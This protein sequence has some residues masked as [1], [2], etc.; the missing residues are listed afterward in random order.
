MNDNDPKVESLETRMA[1]L[2]RGLA[3]LDAVVRTLGDEL[4]ATR[5]E[6]ERVRLTQQAAGDELNSAAKW[7]VPPH[8]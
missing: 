5:A 8:Y 2:E 1:W 6:L 4:R 7:E 3:D